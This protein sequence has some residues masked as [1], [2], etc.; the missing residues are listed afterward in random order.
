MML[1]RHERH[2]FTSISCIGLMLFLSVNLPSCTPPPV[3]NGGDNGGGDGSDDLEFSAEN[4]KIGE[5][6][7]I[8]HSSIV[9]GEIRTVSFR[10]DDGFVQ[11]HEVTPHADGE[12]SIAMPPYYDPSNDA[13]VANRFAISIDGV[14]I[15]R[16]VDVEGLY[17]LEGVETGA[18]IGLLI[19][20]TL[21]DI[22]ASLQRLDDQGDDF[23]TTAENEAFRNA[24]LDNRDFYE[25][26]RAEWDANQTLTFPVSG[27]DD[28][29][30]QADQVREAERY[31]ANIII[32]AHSEI[33]RRN[34]SETGRIIGGNC[35]GQTGAALQSCLDQCIQD[36]KDQ[37]LRASQVA[38][39][40]PTAVGAGITLF[41]FLVVSSEA[42]IITGVVVTVAGMAHGFATA[43][44]SNTNTDTFGQN[45]GEGF[46]ASREAISQLVRYGANA[47]S[48]PVS[49][50][51]NAKDLASALEAAKCDKDNQGQRVRG[52]D[53]EIQFCEVVLDDFLQNVNVNITGLGAGSASSRFSADF[54]VGAALDANS[55][56]SWFSNGGTEQDN[57]EVFTWQLVDST[58][59]II[60]RVEVDPE[61]F[62][63]GGKFGFAAGT[64]QIL[65]AN[66]GVVYSQDY[67]FAGSRVVI[68]QAIP[69]GVQG[70]TVQLIL[71]GHQDKSC[72]GFAELR[73]FGRQP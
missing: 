16:D 45:E 46:N 4:L 18:V 28:I 24:L 72:G 31:L 34:G 15:E 22:D 6:L 2:L 58:E 69:E 51:I 29:T 37:A 53:P 12:L 17:D 9:E 13:I 70:R 35:I 14:D 27:G 67:G 21:E 68:D 59:Y 5:F 10:Q 48:A 33:Q 36:I 52:D 39:V 73:V 41:G 65:N 20:S 26:L 32:G 60:S 50:A 49:L 40:I 54:P 30:V 25:G 56:T 44:A 7:T 42:V 23:D 43:F 47:G 11:Q 8:R 57:T 19:D 71:V 1:N 3:D 61:Q 66:D 63:G 55:F 64:L 62:E 38:G